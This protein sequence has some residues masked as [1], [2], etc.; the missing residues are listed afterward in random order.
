MLIS[1]LAHRLSRRPSLVALAHFRG[2]DGF[3]SRP[4][5][6]RCAGFLGWPP[7]VLGSL[8]IADI[9]HAVAGR[10]RA[11]EPMLLFADGA[12]APVMTRAELAAY[13]R[14]DQKIS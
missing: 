6:L 14:G 13:Q 7:R 11:V 2:P 9:Q 4:A 1:A 3:L 10:L 12:S 5:L 8:S